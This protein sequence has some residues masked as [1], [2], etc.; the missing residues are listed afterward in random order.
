MPTPLDYAS[1]LPRDGAERPSGAAD[2]ALCLVL[3]VIALQTL[4][5][6][7]V[8]NFRSGSPLP[9][10]ATYAGKWRTSPIVD[11]TSFRYFNSQF[12]PA[13]MSR[14]LSPAERDSIRENVARNRLR[15]VVETWGLAQYLIVPL[16][17][18]VSLRIVM[19][20]RRALAVRIL[21]GACF[22]V[23]LLAGTSA[24]HRGYFS[25]LGI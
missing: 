8:L 24:L 19:Q 15:G 22:T 4:V 25:S 5:R 13:L 3:A 23:Q 14:P 7:E 6:I 11:E 21:G 9:H 17:L 1:P 10:A 16:G 12:D 2:V 20:R 18:V